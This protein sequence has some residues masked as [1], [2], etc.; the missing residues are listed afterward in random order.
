MILNKL[1]YCIFPTKCLSCGRVIGVDECICEECN[2]I[3]KPRPSAKLGNKYLTSC[4]YSFY[5]EGNVKR[6]IWRFK[7]R[8][9]LHYGDI[10]AKYMLD[11]FNEYY[12]NSRIDYIV[13]VPMSKHKKRSRGYNQTEILAKL[14]S[15]K[16]G[17]PC[18]KDGLIKVKDNK[19]QHGMTLS[20]RRVN[21]KGVFGVNK[22]IDFHGKRVIIIDD[23]LTTGLTMY[24]CAK[25]VKKSGAEAVYGIGIAAA[26]EEALVD[27]R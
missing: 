12:F 3:Y 10:F 8:S 19:D 25:M 13:A 15:K 27:Y 9:K 1:L 7:F 20:E 22:N 4:A 23:V 6:A 21:I 2:K 26:S 14:L 24:E 5:Y 11:C 18:V 16:C 17:V